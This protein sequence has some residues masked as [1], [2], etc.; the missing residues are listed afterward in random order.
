MLGD[1]WLNK[2]DLSESHTAFKFGDGRKIL[3]EKKRNNSR[4]NN[5]RK[6]NFGKNN[7]RKNR[8]H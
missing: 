2:I 1:T 5:S 6:N 8:T 7:S 4:K 3:S